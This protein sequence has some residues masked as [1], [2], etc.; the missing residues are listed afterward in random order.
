[1]KRIQSNSVISEYQTTKKNSEIH[2]NSAV[3]SLD[4]MRS[5]IKSM[6]LEIDKL[7]NPQKYIEENKK[8]SLRKSK[9]QPRLNKRVPKSMGK[10]KVFQS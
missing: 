7:K 8:V 5:K 10:L 1:M 4:L 3:Q 2:Y 6:T 9:S